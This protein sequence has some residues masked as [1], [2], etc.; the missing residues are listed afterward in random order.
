MTFVLGLASFLIL[1]VHSVIRGRCDRFDLLY[2]AKDYRVTRGF[3]DLHFDTE[4][5]GYLC[6]WFHLVYD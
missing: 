1:K 6:G 4:G 2:V 3:R 5:H